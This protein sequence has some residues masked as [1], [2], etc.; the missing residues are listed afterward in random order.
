MNL[1]ISDF[2]ILTNRHVVPLSV[3]VFLLMNAQHY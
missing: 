3:M 2:A 1:G